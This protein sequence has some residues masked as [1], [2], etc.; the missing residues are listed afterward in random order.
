MV[1]LVARRGQTVYLNG[2]GHRDRENGVPMTADTIFRVASMTK[3]ITSLAILMLFEEGKLQLTD[4][5]S[6]YV[7]D[8][9]S[10]KVWTL[11][12]SATSKV[13]QR[14]G[15][16]LCTEP[17]SCCSGSRRRPPT[18]TLQPASAKPLAIPA[19]IPVPPPVMATT[20]PAS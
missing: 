9:K 5:V 16:G 13:W 2:V 3:P 8:F 15:W 20:F 4:P 12:G 14:I 18:V 11:D 6:A 19:P 10:M 7:S 1:S 17:D